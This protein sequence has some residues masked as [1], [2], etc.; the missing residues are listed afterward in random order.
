MHKRE[1]LLRT[2]A[3]TIQ[4]L[5]AAG[6]LRVGIDGVDGAGKTMFADELAAV[7]RGSPRE[8]IRA[9]TDSFHNPRAIRYRLGRQSPEG[10]YA[11]SFNLS[12]LR[13]VLLDPLSP[14]GSRRYRTAMFDH[15]TDSE[16]VAPEQHAT[17]SA[18]L[19]FDGIFLQRPELRPYWDFSVFLDVPF[20]ISIAR[21]AGRDNGM[22][23]PGALENRRYVEG[24]KLYLGSCSPQSR[25]TLV[26][27]NSDLWAPYIVE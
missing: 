1:L 14:G 8:V 21:C 7:L 12:A 9:S 20:L 25:A 18:I 2:V 27:D 10:F 11:D 17:D 3:D 15:L 4:A 24:Q 23:D 19:I 22:P 13:E 6:V 26:V 16:V 5:P